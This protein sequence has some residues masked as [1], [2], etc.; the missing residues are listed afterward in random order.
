[1]AL[2]LLYQFVGVLGAQVLVGFLEG[3]VFGGLINPWVDRLLAAIIPWEV[4]RNLIG[5]EYGIVTL[6]VRYAV[7]LILPIVG[8]FFLAF[9]VIEDSGSCATGDADRRCSR[10]SG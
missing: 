3:T 8:T 9:S 7:A 1:V 6:G 5:G 2:Y 10:R 4:V